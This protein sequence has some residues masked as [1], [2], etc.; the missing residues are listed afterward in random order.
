MNRKCTKWS[1]NI[2]NVLKILQMAINISTFSNLRYSKI[3]PNL[4]FWFENKPSGNLD[5]NAGHS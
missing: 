4:A 3:Y 1:Y 2:P 5:G